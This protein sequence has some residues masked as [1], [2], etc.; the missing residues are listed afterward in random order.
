MNIRLNI[1]F[2]PNLIIIIGLSL[3]L[4]FTFSCKNKSDLPIR[5]DTSQNATKLENKNVAKNSASTG[6]SK[7]NK[8]TYDK[9]QEKLPKLID[10]GAD[11]CIPCKLMKPILEE[12]KTKYEGRLEVEIIDVWENPK[13]GEKYNISLIPT[14]IF[15]DP[16]GKEFYRHEG[17]MSKEDILKTFKQKGINLD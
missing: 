6:D 10:L 1:N 11:K 12:M 3:L 2:T 16:D 15:F 7:F 5:T 13:E 8:A 17:F 4:F 9:R 14:Q